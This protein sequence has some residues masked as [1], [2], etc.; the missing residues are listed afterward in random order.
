MRCC[1]ESLDSEVIHDF[2]KPA[3][4]FHATGV[5]FIRHNLFFRVQS[6][7]FLHHLYIW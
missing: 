2:V 1:V 5:D 7:D 3:G 6:V 4:D